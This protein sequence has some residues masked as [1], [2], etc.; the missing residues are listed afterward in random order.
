MDI[1]RINYTAAQL[2][3]AGADNLS[4]LLL[5]GLFLNE[6]NWLQK[7]LLI[8]TM[9]EP[10][11]EPEHRAHLSLSLML[12]KLIAAKMLEGWLRMTSNPMKRTLDALALPKDVLEL[13][14]KL[15]P[16]LVKDSIIYKVRNF[17][18]GHYPTKLSLDRLPGINPGDVVLFMTPYSGDTISTISELAAAAELANIAPAPMLHESVDE[19]LKQTVGAL[20]LYCSFMHGVLAELLCEKVQGKPSHEELPNDAPPLDSVKLRF[21]AAPLRSPM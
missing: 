14:A 20:G 1:T 19:I 4:A 21:F 6:A 9:D 7:L 2:E 15:E 3:S 13:R 8:S 10:D 11:T 5:I 17:H 18:G 12:A 16:L